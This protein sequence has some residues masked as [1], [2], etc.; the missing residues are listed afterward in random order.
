M[1]KILY[2]VLLSIVLILY[3]INTIEPA[4]CVFYI[5]K[6][7]KYSNIMFLTKVFDVYRGK[8]CVEKMSQ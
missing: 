8:V 7:L 5:S 4:T 3:F 1:Y 6:V 2:G